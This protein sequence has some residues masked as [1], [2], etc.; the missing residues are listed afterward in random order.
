MDRGDHPGAQVAGHG[1]IP[2]LGAFQLAEDD[3]LREVDPGRA[4]QIRQLLHLRGG[5]VLAVEQRRRQLPVLLGHDHMPAGRNRPQ[6]GLD[7]VVLPAPGGPTTSTFSRG[8]SIN[9]ARNRAATEL[10]ESYSTRSSSVV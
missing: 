2:C 3:E 10:S 9:T 4:D 7:Q 5:P 1:Q 6:Q 8:T